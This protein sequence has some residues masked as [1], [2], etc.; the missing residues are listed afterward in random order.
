MKLEKQ[1]KQ[2]KNRKAVRISVKSQCVIGPHKCSCQMASKSI[3]RFNSVHEC[4]RRQTD[5]PRYWAM[6]S[7]RRNSVR[8][9]DSRTDFHKTIFGVV[10]SCEWWS[11][12]GSDGRDGK[13]GSTGLKELVRTVGKR[14]YLMND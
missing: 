7:Y 13:A 12:A 14:I 8:Y 11:D 2:R 9:S 6:Y 3:E 4:D 1:L 5:R 10:S